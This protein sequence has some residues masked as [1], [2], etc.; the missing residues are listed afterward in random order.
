MAA[1][2]SKGG[3]TNV[4]DLRA[5]KA[6]YYYVGTSFEGLKISHVER[7]QHGM[8][9]SHLTAPARRAATK[10]ARLRWNCNIGSVT[11]P[12]RS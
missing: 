6:P 8:A 11:A 4:D 3:S 2:C 5:S 9:T 7:Y 10:G 12:S 1:G